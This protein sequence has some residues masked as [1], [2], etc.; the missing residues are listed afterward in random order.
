M[1]IRMED[2]AWPEIEDCLKKPNAVLVPVGSIEQHGRHLPL[3]VDYRCPAYVAEVAA[4]KVMLERDFSIL[5]A[6]SFQY[7]EVSL[8]IKGFPGCIGLTTD[9]AIRAFEDVARSFIKS[10]FNNI[11]FVNGHSTNMASLTIALRKVSADFPSAGLYVVRWLH[12][13]FDVIPKVRKSSWGLHAEEL[14]TSASLVIQPENVHMER[15]VK[16]L[17]VFSLSDRWIKMDICGDKSKIAFHTRQKYP[18]K[19][20]GDSGVIGDPT[21]ATRE[22][23]EAILEASAVDLARI[24]VEV[25]AGNPDVPE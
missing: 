13:G 8:A 22:T 25:I 18:E 10:G 2:L 14:E 15:A 7:G 4:G 12:L 16:E 20:R 3:S 11:I 5:V 1:K 17:P 21:S 9:T 6:P 19:S 24:I 23:G